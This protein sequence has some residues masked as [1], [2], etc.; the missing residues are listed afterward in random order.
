MIKRPSGVKGLGAAS[1]CGAIAAPDDSRAS[2]A[3]PVI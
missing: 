1:V 2:S 3:W